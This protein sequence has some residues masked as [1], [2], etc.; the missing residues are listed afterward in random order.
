MNALCPSQARTLQLSDVALS[1]HHAGPCMNESGEWAAP[2][3][4]APTEKVASNT[5]APS[6]DPPRQ[7][8]T[9]PDC[10]M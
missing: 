1:L 6:N 10:Y 9:G 4:G 5:W 2:D 7:R 3:A 8:L